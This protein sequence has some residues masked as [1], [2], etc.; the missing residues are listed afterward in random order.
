M[1]W[2][3]NNKFNRKVNKAFA[4]EKTSMAKKH[5]SFASETIWTFFL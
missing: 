1:L 4:T 3:H 2:K 5:V